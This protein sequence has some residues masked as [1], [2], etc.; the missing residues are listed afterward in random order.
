MD[1]IAFA[2]QNHDSPIGL[3]EQAGKLHLFRAAAQGPRLC[4]PKDTLRG[5]I[6]ESQAMLGVKGKYRRVHGRNNA[7]QQSAGLKLIQTLALQQVSKF[8]DLQ[9][10][11]SKRIVL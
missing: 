5:G 4:E 2:A 1:G 7:P 6:D 9:G 3:I 8:V 10:K 11:L